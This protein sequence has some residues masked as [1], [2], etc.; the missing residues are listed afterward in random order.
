MELRGAADGE[1]AL[2]EIAAEKPDAIILDLMMPGLDGFHVLEQLQASDETRL[3]PV[4][5][6]TARQLSSNERARL[7]DRTVSLLEKSA[8]SPQ[9]LRRLVNR[10]LAGPAE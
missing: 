10:L 6:L 4:I 9:E 1:T 7:R 3:L 5:V 8:Y 2:V